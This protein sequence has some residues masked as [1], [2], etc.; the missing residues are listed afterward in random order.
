MCLF[1]LGERD[2]DNQNAPQPK[3]LLGVAL[4]MQ[5]GDCSNVQWNHE[6]LKNTCSVNKKDIQAVV[7]SQRR[8]ANHFLPQSLLI[9]CGAEQA[10]SYSYLRIMRIA[11][12]PDLQQQGLGHFFIENIIK[13]AKQQSVDFVG[14]SF[15]ANKALMSFWLAAGFHPV[16]LGFTQDKASG[17][18]SVL[19][20]KGLNEKTIAEQSR[21]TCNFYR[22]FDYL[23][24]DEYQTVKGELIFILLTQLGIS[25]HI[26]ASLTILTDLDI[27][28][29]KAFAEGTR[30]Y[31]SCAYSLYIWFKH[32][33]ANADQT[34][35]NADKTGKM[36]LVFIA[37]L[38]QKR[39]IDDVC[40]HFGFTGKK[41]LNKAMKN[42]VSERL[43][44]NV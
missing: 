4:L 31:S 26:S 41:A 6:Q 24:L 27:E 40:R 37:R 42:Y 11:I 15:G 5:E 19:V 21:L 7:N 16:R 9:H 39:S 44:V 13:Q 20:L 29:V 3:N 33:L 43:T 8:L 25:D 32:E 17:E 34:K 10:F 12:H 23:L 28:N 38:L 35:I 22:S 18:H 36:A 30:V 2:K 14:A 1:E